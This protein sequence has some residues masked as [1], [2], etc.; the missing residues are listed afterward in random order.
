MWFKGWLLHEDREC[1]EFYWNVTVV[2]G[3]QLIKKICVLSFF[4]T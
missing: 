3:I 4:W 1:N 2:Q